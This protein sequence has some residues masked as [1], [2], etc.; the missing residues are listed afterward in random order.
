MLS[1]A[2]RSLAPK[3][4]ARIVA[5]I[6]PSFERISF[7]L[8]DGTL[9]RFGAAERL[10]AKNEVLDAL[11]ARLEATGEEPRPTST[12]GC[13]R[14]PRSRRRHHHDAGRVGSRR[15]SFSNSVAHTR[16]SA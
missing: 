5:V 1:R 4:R 15:N 11:L 10:D 3:L 9:I 8:E 7:S 6:A 16:V 13:R 14:V 12:C 2:F